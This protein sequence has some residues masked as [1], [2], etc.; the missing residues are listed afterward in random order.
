[1]EKELY[2]KDIGVDCDLMVCKA[3]L[4]YLHAS[5]DALFKCLKSPA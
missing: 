3:F 2:V 1:M 4:P 5:I